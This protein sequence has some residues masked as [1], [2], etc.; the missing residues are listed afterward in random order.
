MKSILKEIENFLNYLKY[1]KNVSAHTIKNYRFDLYRFNEY[2]EEKNIQLN[3][4]DNVSIRGFMADC[5]K[6][7][8]SKSTIARRLAAIR[9]FFQYLI[10][11]GKLKD[12]P[13]KVISTPKQEKK[14]P[15]FLTEQEISTLLDS[16]KPS[17]P[18][19]ARDKAILELLY[20][21]GMRLSELVSLNLEDVNLREQLVRVK[22]KG[23]KE[24]VIPFG[25]IALQSLNNYLKLR[26][27]INK[28]RVD[29]RALFLN[30][31]GKRISPRSVERI[32]E[33]YVKQLV[34]KR[35]VSPHSI[36]HSFASHLLSRGADLRAIQEL[37]GHESLSTTQKY[38]HLNLKRLI[39]IYKK[40]HPRS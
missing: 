1:Q 37:L 38:T 9:S 40:A 24:R 12:N 19:E 39:E 7:G 22:G 35:K 5:F 3:K 28:G 18:L 13:A 2:L 33:K 17:T 27:T 8:E 32:L 21:T 34:I 16:I 6:R 15:S 36:R 26:N 23:K 11:R 31:Q 10:R 20:A 4:V 25:R 29:A 30:Y 14:I